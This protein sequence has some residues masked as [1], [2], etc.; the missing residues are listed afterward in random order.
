[1][2]IV[3]AL[4]ADPSTPLSLEVFVIVLTND[5]LK[6]SNGATKMRWNKKDAMNI[7]FMEAKILVMTLYHD[8]GSTDLVVKNS[9]F[10]TK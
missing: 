5:L 3:S 9:L 8:M 2:S 10:T 7:Q 6:L 4:V 1:M